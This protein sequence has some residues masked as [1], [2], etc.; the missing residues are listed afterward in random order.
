MEGL[1]LQS[2]KNTLF[3]WQFMFCFPKFILK[4]RAKTQTYHIFSFPASW[5]IHE[6]RRT[7]RHS[8]KRFLTKQSAGLA[9][10]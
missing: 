6:P 8:L 10:A 5:Y 1:I 7:M 9:A 2:L 3:V 4:T